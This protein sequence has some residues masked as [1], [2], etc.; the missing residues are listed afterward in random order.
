V[1]QPLLK[2]ETR[3]KGGEHEIL[4]T[5]TG[6]IDGARWDFS[7]IRGCVSDAEADKG[8]DLSRRAGRPEMEHSTNLKSGKAV[9]AEE[10]PIHPALDGKGI[11]KGSRIH[12][13]SD[14]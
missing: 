6:M 13:A 3:S 8:S 10:K 2:F 9:A 12:Q 14:A 5:C 11:S 1:Q 4:Q 7:E